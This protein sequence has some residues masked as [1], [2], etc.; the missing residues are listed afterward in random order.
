MS[1]NNMMDLH[2]HLFAQL[3]RLSDEEVKG[4]EL[5]EEIA[6][7]NAIKGVAETIIANARLVADVNL[8]YVNSLEPARV[9]KM[10]ALGDMGED[11]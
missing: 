1:K 10:L 6:R 5:K 8:R 7:G 3:E 9:P 4:D 2:N 11:A